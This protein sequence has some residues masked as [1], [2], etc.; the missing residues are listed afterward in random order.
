[1]VSAPNT[2]WLFHENKLCKAFSFS[3]FIDAITFVNKVADISEEYNHHPSIQ[4]DYTTVRLEVTTHSK[5]H[6]VTDK[7]YKLAEAINLIEDKEND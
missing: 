7:D 5:G 4:V 1:M 3:S 2:D 6:I